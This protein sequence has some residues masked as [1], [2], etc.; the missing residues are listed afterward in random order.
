MKEVMVDMVTTACLPF[1]FL[2]VYLTNKKLYSKFSIPIALRQ[3]N[4][5]CEYQRL[6][7]VCLIVSC[8]PSSSSYHF[9]SLCVLSPFTV[10]PPYHP[11]WH[12]TSSSL[13]RVSQK[14]IL[15][16]WSVS[17]AVSTYVQETFWN[18][19][20]AFEGFRHISWNGQRYGSRFQSSIK[21]TLFWDTLPHT[22]STKDFGKSKPLGLWGRQRHEMNRGQDW[23]K[24]MWHENQT[25]FSKDMRI[26]LL[27]PHLHCECTD[28][29]LTDV[30]NLGEGSALKAFYCSDNPPVANTGL[31]LFCHTAFCILLKLKTLARSIGK[32]VKGG[33]IFCPRGSQF[34][35]KTHFSDFGPKSWP[36]PGLDWCATH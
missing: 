15:G 20:T 3:L 29:K 28:V 11:C 32:E 21:L 27:L 4:Q 19:W 33:G 31:I 17:V 6:F 30:G 13:Y 2:I 5:N 18:S 26:E 12:L 24:G 22:Y 9:Q 1:P 23:R 14:R 8:A 25:C 16:S 7:L 36:N 34:Q 10:C 35:Q